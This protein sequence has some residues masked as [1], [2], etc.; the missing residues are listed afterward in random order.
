MKSE[1]IKKRIEQCVTLFEFEYKGKEGN[2][3]PYYIPELKKTKYL[4]FFD[5]SETTVDTIDEVMT[6][7]FIDGKNI[8]EIC[9][10]IVV[11]DW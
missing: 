5:G 3:D 1:M 10:E 6:T 9:N 11:I 8:N 4:L 7:P 2:I